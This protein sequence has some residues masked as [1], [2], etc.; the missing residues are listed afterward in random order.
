[1]GAKISKGVK[2]FQG[3]GRL[4]AMGDWALR[5]MGDFG[6]LGD[7]QPLKPFDPPVCRCLGQEALFAFRRKAKTAWTIAVYA[8]QASLGCEPTLGLVF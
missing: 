7:K 6:R 2:R 5:A 1:M 3:S 4:W 8:P